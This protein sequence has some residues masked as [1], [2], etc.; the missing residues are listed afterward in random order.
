[1]R[2]S[3]THFIGGMGIVYMTIT[4]I[5]SLGINRSEVINAESEGP[6]IVHYDD[7]KEAIA[8]GFAF[9]KVYA[10]LTLVLI[11]ALTISGYLARLTPYE[12]RY[13]SIF[14]AINYAFSTMGTG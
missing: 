7:E 9:F 5:R 6:H 10:L 3:V 14:D 4:F 11:V 12:M 1:M 2:R 13:D 8:S